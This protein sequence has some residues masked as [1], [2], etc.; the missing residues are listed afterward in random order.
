MF[1]HYAARE[2]DF[3]VCTSTFSHTPLFLKVSRYIY[4]SNFSHLINVESFPVL[5]I[6]YSI[7]FFRKST[8]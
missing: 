1:R 4:I 7:S 6:L 8:E 5:R 3:A 2:M